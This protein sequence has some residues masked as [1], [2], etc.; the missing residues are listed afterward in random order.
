MKYKL[1]EK[2]LT[3]G[4]VEFDNGVEIES[5]V[6]SKFLD[7]AYEFEDTIDKD[8]NYTDEYL[9][10]ETKKE[11]ELE[12]ILLQLNVI[13]KP[14]HF[15][16]WNSKVGSSSFYNHTKYWLGKGY[17]DFVKEFNNL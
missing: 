14:K 8:G 6:I 7:E 11:K 16:I 4:V 17:F 9:Y 15:E 10:F 1:V 12:P 2:V 13:R 3:V 5:N